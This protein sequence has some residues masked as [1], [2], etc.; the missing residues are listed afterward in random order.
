MAGGGTYANLFCA[1][2]PFQIDGNFGGAAGIA[3]MLIQSH[4]GV[5][6]LLPALPESWS[7]GRVAGL[8]ARGG[9]VVDLQWRGG[10]L[11]EA[12]IRSLA[13]GLLRLRYAGR[14][15]ER[16]MRPGAAITVRGQDFS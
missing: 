5:V 9:F 14:T 1:H 7:E 3:E 12:R 16:A 13:G 6:R 11:T 2:P 8:R 10:R 4:N 15:L